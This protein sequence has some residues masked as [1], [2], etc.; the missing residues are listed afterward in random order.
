MRL[1][2]FAVLCICVFS[3]FIFRFLLIKQNLTLLLNL[4]LSNFT[5]I[6]F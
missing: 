5:A 1:S 6:K 3:G 2:R 4:F